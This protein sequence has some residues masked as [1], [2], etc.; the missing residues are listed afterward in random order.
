MI[1]R[2]AES[3][4]WMSRYME[5][6][7]ALARF[8]DVN[9]GFVLDVSLPPRARWRPLVIVVGEQKTFNRLQGAGAAAN[10]EKVQSFLTW[11]R[12]NTS[13]LASSLY[14]AR[15]NARTIRETISLE[16]WRVLNELWLWFA[17]R[18]ARQLY[19]RDRPAF[20]QHISEQCLLFQGVARNT[21]LHEEPLDFMELGSVLER[22]GQTARILDV[23]YH[24]LGPL[25]AGTETPIETAQWL[26][27]LRSC[28]GVEPFVKRAGEDLSGLAVA[29][30]LLL[31]RAFPHAVLHNLE[32]A[33]ECL[34][35]I[36][37]VAPAGVGVRSAEVLD[38]LHHDIASLNE[39][40]LLAK[41][42]HEVL[43]EVVERTALVC[44]ALRSDFFAPAAA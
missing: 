8:L 19:Q 29:G 17:S 28:L 33:R 20:Y 10:A 44:D 30:F 27:I 23:K 9:Q 3:C 43:T 35:D 31:D 12:A 5:R 18:P 40:A 24:G 14:W 21:M 39:E 2:V 4:F 37:R 11:E 15:E 7:E 34:G 22:G 41:G 6:L 26:A 1:S 13:S 25:R 16:M 42:L 32:R 38:S 36:R